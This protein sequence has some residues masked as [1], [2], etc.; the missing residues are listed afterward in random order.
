MELQVIFSAGLCEIR[1]P[2]SIFFAPAQIEK[3]AVQGQQNRLE[4]LIANKNEVPRCIM[5]SNGRKEVE[6]IETSIGVARPL[7]YQA[8]I[9]GRAH[10]MPQ[11]SIGPKLTAA[12]VLVILDQTAGIQV[13]K[14]S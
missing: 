8:S 4:L 7:R 2:V 12:C 10:H 14:E 3:T 1:G 13:S 9:E 6:H 5:S 11:G